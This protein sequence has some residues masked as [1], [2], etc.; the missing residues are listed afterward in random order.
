MNKHFYFWEKVDWYNI[1]VLNEREIR[2]WAWIFFATWLPIFL[3]SCINMDFYITKIFITLF[4]IDFFIRVCIN[5]KYSPSLIIARFFVWNQKPEY[6][7]AS[8]KR[9]AWAIWLILSIIMFIQIWIFNLFNLLSIFICILCLIFLFFESAFWI[10]IWCKIYN[11]FSKNKAELCPWWIC[12]ITKKEE[13]Q[14]INLTQILIVILFLLFLIWIIY[15]WFFTSN[16]QNS[17][18]II[19][20]PLSWNDNIQDN[21]H[22][23][24]NNVSKE[25]C[26]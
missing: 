2:G 20:C 3:I 4:M 25:S 24:N 22:I 5:P 18:C 9:F 8:Q 14:K 21:N 12:E 10:C 23:I 13:I 17:F 1:R 19:W 26:K 15:S 11:F 6:V 16:K 7:W